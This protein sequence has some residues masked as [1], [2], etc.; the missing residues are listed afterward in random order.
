MK[1]SDFGKYSVI[2]LAV[3]TLP[4]ILSLPLN[5]LISRKEPFTTDTKKLLESLEKISKIKL[6]DNNK[7][8]IIQM[9]DIEN[10]TKG[11]G[12]GHG[13]T[14]TT[15][16]RKETDYLLQ[17]EYIIGIFLDELNSLME[18]F[19]FTLF[20]ISDIQEKDGNLLIDFFILDI[21][22]V[23]SRIK[24]LSNLPR[25]ILDPVDIKSVKL[26]NQDE[27]NK[28]NKNTL[29]QPFDK[30]SPNT[31]EIDNILSIFTLQRQ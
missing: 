31:F 7:T 6:N 17:A 3:I 1:R 22:D 10:T 2:M 25:N 27:N 23:I 11:H 12:F 24:I 13:T 28:N 26:I 5:S 20:N 19:D 18:T 21:N 14:A 8:Y 30:G 16:V 4:L 9:L 29:P 15:L